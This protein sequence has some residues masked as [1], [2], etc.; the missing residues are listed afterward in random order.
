MAWGSELLIPARD[1]TTGVVDNTSDLVELQPANQAYDTGAVTLTQ[2]T[3]DD[4]VW[5]MDSDLLDDDTHYKL[6]KNGSYTGIFIPAP[7]SYPALGE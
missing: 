1:K 2:R 4:Y 6:Y 7:N 5:G 3:I